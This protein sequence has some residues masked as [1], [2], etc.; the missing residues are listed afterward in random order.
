MTVTLT[1]PA[2]GLNVGD[3][4]TGALE[5]WLLAQGYASQDG[6]TGP[7]VQETGSTDVAPADDPRLP[8]NREAP[9]FPETP[10]RHHSIANDATHLTQAS[11]PNPE[12]DLDLGNANT[13]APTEV[14]LET[15]E[16]PAAGGTETTL[17][18]QNLEGTTGVTFGGVAGTALDATQADEG[19][20]KVTT[21]PGAAGPVDVVVTN[22]N[23][24]ETLTGGF[25][26]TA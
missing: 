1:S 25:T 19:I 17:L 14:S 24:A 6:Y 18:G 9:Y 3:A 16:G 4:Y 10:D 26:Y 8:E 21:P 22:A 23:G 12:F 11:N 2:M 20:V 7:G 13:E 5:A 15:T